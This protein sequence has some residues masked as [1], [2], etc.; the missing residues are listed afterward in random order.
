MMNALKTLCNNV[1]LH[2]MHEFWQITLTSTHKNI[3]CVCH[4]FAI[5]YCKY[6]MVDI[7]PN[8]FFVTIALFVNILS[9]LM[10]RTTISLNDLEQRKKKET[11]EKIQT[12]FL[13][14]VL[15][16]LKAKVFAYLQ[17]LG[18]LMAIMIILLMRILYLIWHKGSK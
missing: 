9:Y 1:I 15:D 16:Y 7:K 11:Q 2:S 13:D 6:S 12:T 10:N 18:L 17:F 4:S 14:P 8:F 3:C 5:Y